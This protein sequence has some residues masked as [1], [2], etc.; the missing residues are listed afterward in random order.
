[1]A[2]ATLAP[3]Q[4]AGHQAVWSMFNV[5]AFSNATVEQAALAFIPLTKTTREIQETVKIL[6]AMGAANGTLLGCSCFSIAMFLPYV[7]SAD[8]RL[9]PIMATMA[10]F[11]AGTVLLVGIDVAASANL[12]ALGKA[13]YLARSFAICLACLAPYMIAVVHNQWGIVGVWSGLVLFFSLRCTQS[14]HAIWNL[15]VWKRPWKG[16]I[17]MGSLAC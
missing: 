7:F 11:C 10:P 15:E 9:Y 8:A 14:L 2:A 4:L 1:M 17:E 3:L 12:I 13:Q 16:D 6:M 5:C